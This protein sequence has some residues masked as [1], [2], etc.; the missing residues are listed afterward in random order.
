MN[1]QENR[2]LHFLKI[3]DKKIQDSINL[4]KNKLDNSPAKFLYKLDGR[5]Q[6]FQLQGLARIECVIGKN[7]KIAKKWL[8]EFKSIEDAL[9]KYDYWFVLLEKQTKMKLNEKIEN[10]IKEQINIQVGYIEYELLKYGWIQKNGTCTYN[11]NSKGLEK[12]IKLLPKL[13]WHKP[14]KE[15][16]LLASFF[17]NECVKIQNLVL[18]KQIDLNDVEHGI[19]ELRRKLRWIAIYCSCLL[20]KVKIEKIEKNDSLK[21]YVTKENINN[22]FNNLPKFKVDSPL[23]FTQGGFYAMNILIA[24]MGEIKDKALTTEEFIQIGAWFNV[25]KNKIENVLGKDFISEMKVRNN[26]KELV[27]NFIVKEAILNNIVSHFE[28]Q[29]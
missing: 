23:Y 25:T 27:N 19:H 17:K 24:D 8:I 2:F 21:I 28:N 16:T 7:K 6:M 26:T 18:E 13:K 11:Y 15:K 9:G 22:K 20:G 1:S 3:F 29:I 12:Y 5:T 4:N 10:F 14:K